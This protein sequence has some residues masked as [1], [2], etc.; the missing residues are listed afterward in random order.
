MSN[1][2]KQCCSNPKLV[3]VT[4]GIFALFGFLALIL[5]GYV[6]NES[7]E[8]RAYKGDFTPEQTAQRWANLKEVKEAQ[9]A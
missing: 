6:G 4:L 5:S 8:D 9:T 1:S 2:G 7:P 3:L